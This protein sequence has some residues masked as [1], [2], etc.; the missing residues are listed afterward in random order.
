MNRM[1]SIVKDMKQE[2]EKKESN[3]KNLVKQVKDQKEKC[4]ERHHFQKE[5][6]KLEEKAKNWKGKNGKEVDWNVELSIRLE[7]S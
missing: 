5:V 1:R 2:I 6:R 4:K 3:A 7:Y